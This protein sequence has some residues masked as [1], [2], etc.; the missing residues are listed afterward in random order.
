[1]GDGSQRSAIR[2]RRDKKGAAMTAFSL[3][4]AQTA[5]C[6]ELRTLA[7]ERLRPL[8]EK[9]ETGRLNRPLLAALGELGLL[10]RMFGSGALD[11]CLLRE[12]LARG[13]TEAET[14][15]A[16]QGLGTTP[17]VRAGTPAQ[18]ARW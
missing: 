7:E 2:Q 8:A 14:A 15:L 11:L 1:M 12:S 6:E 13:C 9:G 5:W 18:R 4:P 16:L 17:V 10:E 3:E